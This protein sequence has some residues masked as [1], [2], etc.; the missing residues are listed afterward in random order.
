MTKDQGQHNAGEATKDTDINKK[1][2]KEVLHADDRGKTTY[3]N[4]VG[5]AF[6][7]K[8]GNGLVA[9]TVFGTLI[10]RSPEERLEQQKSGSG[11]RETADKEREAGE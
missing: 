2:P 4:K 3:Y 5:V 11:V 6:D 8:D 7:K 10:I 9:R 1:Q